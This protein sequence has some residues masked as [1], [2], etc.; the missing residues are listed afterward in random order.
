MMHQNHARD[1]GAEN[2]S[3]WNRIPSCSRVSARL[4]ICAEADWL[5][6]DRYKFPHALMD[7]SSVM[8]WLFAAECSTLCGKE[9]H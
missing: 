1:S 6:F 8:D 5:Y 4:V 7:I 9:G 2:G 3:N